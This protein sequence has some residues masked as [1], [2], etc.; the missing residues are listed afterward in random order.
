MSG[1]LLLSP[2]IFKFQ[3]SSFLFL[4]DV[5]GGNLNASILLKSQNG[6]VAKGNSSGTLLNI[7]L[8]SRNFSQGMQCLWGPRQG[9]KQCPSAAG[10]FQKAQ[11]PGR[12]WQQI[13]MPSFLCG[14]LLLSSLPCSNL[15]YRGSDQLYSPVGG[16]VPSQAPTFTRFHSPFILFVTPIPFLPY[17]HH[18]DVY[19]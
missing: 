18:S 15:A 3:M 6:Q 10:I 11:L 5:W 16:P 7:L 9:H 12:G 2:L 19:F 17:G 13:N 4:E 1:A 8:L 14:A